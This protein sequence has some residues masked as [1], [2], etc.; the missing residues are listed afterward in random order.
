MLTAYTLIRKAI[1]TCGSF[2]TEEAATKQ[3][4]W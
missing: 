4:F 2:P 1:K 3:I